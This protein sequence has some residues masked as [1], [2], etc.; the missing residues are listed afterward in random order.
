MLVK[1][2]AFSDD[3]RAISGFSG[4]KFL[5]RVAEL[6]EERAIIALGVIMIFFIVIM[7]SR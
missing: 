5:S 2:V 4:G 1:T 3:C 6:S 7:E